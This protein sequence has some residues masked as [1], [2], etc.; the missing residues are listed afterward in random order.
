MMRSKHGPL[1]RVA[2]RTS[3]QS[4]EAVAELLAAVFKQN[5][6]TYT[7]AESGLVTATA[8]CAQRCEED[9]RTLKA[10]LQHIRA[11]GLSV[12]PRG[13]SVRRIRR[14]NWAESWKRHFKPLRIG[15][16]LLVL[17]GWIKPSSRETATVVVLDPGLS[18]GTGHHPTTAFCLRELAR[19]RPSTRGQSFLDMGTGSGI[20][21]IAAAKLKYSPVRAFDCDPDS[22]RIAKVNARRNRVGDQVQISRAY[23]AEFSAQEP[24]R[25]DLVCANLTSNVLLSECSGIVDLLGPSGCLVLAGILN[26]EFP[27]IQAAYESAGLKMIRSRTQKEW[28]SGS[29]TRRAG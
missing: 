25:Y 21:A 13:V 3:P 20:L 17:P 22:V 9:L 14:E 5:P 16:R 18:F 8:Y 11:C 6:S 28:R 12:N 24:G 2:V 10:G 1:W 27:Q 26:A 19:Q 15:R 23:V 4:E 7:D 29:F